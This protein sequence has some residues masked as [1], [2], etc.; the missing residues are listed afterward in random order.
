MLS[1]IKFSLYHSFFF[2]NNAICTKFIAQCETTDIV[3]SDVKLKILCNNFGYGI[4]A[5]QDINENTYID[6]NQCI[7]CNYDIYNKLSLIK[8]NNDK[9]ENNCIRINLR[10]CW[11]KY[12]NDLSYDGNIYNYN[13][14]N[15][16]EKTNCV[17]VFLPNG[18]KYIKTIKFICK[19]TELSRAYGSNYWLENS[20]SNKLIYHLTGIGLVSILTVIHK[21]LMRKNISSKYLLIINI[22]ISII[23][24]VRLDRLVI[25]SAYLHLICESL[26]YMITILQSNKILQC[27]N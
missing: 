22:L 25:R 26:L 7:Y 10:D 23:I 12:I 5:D 20:F 13:D 4:Y 9:K 16:K 21:L 2:L 1:K 8:M 3:Y 15:V 6:I 24:T 18:T 19:G 27:N 11:T 14:K 17:F